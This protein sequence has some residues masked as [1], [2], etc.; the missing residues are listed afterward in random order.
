MAGSVSGALQG[1]SALPVGRGDRGTA[2]R[3]RRRTPSRAA[4]TAAA[5]LVL[6]LGACDALP[7][8][9]GDDSPTPHATA[10]MDPGEVAGGAPTAVDPAWL[11][12]PGQEEP[13]VD[14]TEGGTLIPQ[15]VSADG[16]DVTVTGP[17]RLEPEHSY[18]GFVPEGALLPAA[19]E[20]RGVPAEGFEGELGVEDAP[21]PPMVVR[22]RVEVPGEGAAPAAAT[23]QLTV[24]TCDDAPLPEGQFLLRLSGGGVDGPGRG[25][26]DAGWSAS[27]DVLVDV[28]DGGLRPVPGAVSA[29]SG[30]VPAD[31]S[32]L[33][34]RTSLEAVGDGDGLAVSVEDPTT[35]V[36]T[37]VPEGADG[38]GVSAEVTVTSTRSGTRALL[39]AVV[40]VHPGTGAV[41]AGARNTASIPLQWVGEDGVTGAERAW[42]SQGVCGAGAL[43]PGEYR[44]H[45]VAVTLDAAGTTHVVLS[46]PW[47]VAVREEEPAS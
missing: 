36:S 5:L 29:P 11:C 6:A 14:S 33:A 41:V 17:F 12:R 37:R 42:T 16:T 23:A 32:A 10:P 19:P 31:L 3:P 7:V 46:D 13:P 24:G 21:V 27:E 28:V 8:G 15:S 26:Q 40:L 25:A 39:Q 2:P 38:V 44:A 18:S 20:N 9:T 34:C 47:D 4:A 1:P 22:E 43:A 45:A 30:E 35:S